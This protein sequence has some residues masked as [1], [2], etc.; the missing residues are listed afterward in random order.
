[1]AAAAEFLPRYAQTHHVDVLLMGARSRSHLEAA[2]IGSTAEHV[3]ERLPCDVL[4]VKTP[5]LG[6][7]IPF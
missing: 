3:L 5:P 6:A 1:M 7:G 4:I 2:I